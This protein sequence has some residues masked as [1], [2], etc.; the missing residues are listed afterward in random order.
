MFA[1][2]DTAKLKM[3]LSEEEHT[4]GDF[5]PFEAVFGFRPDIA[6]DH[7]TVDHVLRNR[8]ALENELFFDMLLK[9]LGV[10]Q[11]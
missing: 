8:R 1:H 9:A 3:I 4:M 10:S 2:P 7:Q 6:Y 5:E 11:G